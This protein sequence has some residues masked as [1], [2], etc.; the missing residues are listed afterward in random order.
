[1]PHTP[2]YRSEAT[3][4]TPDRYRRPLHGLAVLTAVATFPLVWMGGLVTS[5]GAGMSVPDWPN[6]FGYNMFAVPWDRWLG[7]YAGGVFYEHTHRL[8]GSLLGLLAIALTATAW[9]TSARRGLKWLAT[10]VLLAVIAQGVMGGLRVT[11]VSPLLA[12]AHGVFGQAVFCL[13]AVAAV[14]TGRWWTARASRG[15]SPASP[16]GA[17]TWAALGVVALLGVQLTLGALMRHDPS[18]SPVAMTG[19]GLAI[20]DVPLSYGKLLPPVSAEGVA[21]VNATRAFDLGLP[22]VERWQI[23]LHFAHR[24]GAVAVTA[25]VVALAA[26]AWRRARSDGRGEWAVLAPA[27]LLPVLI[28]G[29][30]TLGV[31][32]VLWRKPA[33]VATAHQALGALTLV[34]AAVALATAWRAFGW[35]RVSA[36]SAVASDDRATGSRDVREPRAE[37]AL[38]VR[39]ASDRADRPEALAPLAAH[40]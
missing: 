23:W 34:T 39:P 15:R 24:L 5:H 36:T 35:R 6:S 14:A 21:V 33:D 13:T 31:L 20:P 4:P 2:D 38:R 40:P 29:Q 32:T 7:D 37:R 26:V 10:G 27:L 12:V 30:V 25:G 18:R 9:A 1:M 17:V 28:A 8:L 11:E 16:G 19:A 3:L 22:P